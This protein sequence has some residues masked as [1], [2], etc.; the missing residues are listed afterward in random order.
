MRFLQVGLGHRSPGLRR[1]G[2]D[3]PNLSCAGVV[4]HR[5][6]RT[7]AEP[8]F[9]DLAAAL[10]RTRPDFVLCLA[11]PGSTPAVVTQCVAAGVP[12]LAEAPLAAGA[13]GAEQ[14]AGLADT[15]LVQVIEPYP[16]LPDQAAALAAVRAGLIGQ[17]GQVQLSGL[18]AHGAMALLQAYLGP[19][20]PV[21]VRLARFPAES[22]QP[23]VLGQPMA[24]GQPVTLG[25]PGPTHRTGPGWPDE[26][27]VA[28]VEFAGGAIGVYAPRVPGRTSSQTDSATGSAT[29]ATTPSTH[30][31]PFLVR[32]TAGEI[33]GRVLTRLDD[34]AKV[35]TWR[36]QR[37][38]AQPADGA[39]PR[40]ASIHLA[41]TTV[42]SNPQPDQDWSDAEIAGGAILRAMMA[43][44]RGEGPG[45]YGLAEALA[46]TRLVLA[47]GQA[48]GG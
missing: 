25:R 10:E 45:P 46:D 42:W 21:A 9:T 35:S 31:R 47:I 6:V 34:P 23:T 43:F 38:Y 12:V 27:L 1:V 29:A 24:L 41:D 30:P 2:A 14:L 8:V 17:V 22:G 4:L 40:L 26:P 36:F 39:G 20:E 3:L 5:P 15:G 33:V 19:A 7:A 18:P 48:L 11:R 16:W 32:G 37:T 13:A 44:V 28:T